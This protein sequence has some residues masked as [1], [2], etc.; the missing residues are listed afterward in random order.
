LEAADPAA[1]RERLVAP[2]DAA[3]TPAPAPQVPVEGVALDAAEE[4][5]GV[6]F[7][8]G[9]FDRGD[10]AA[11]DPGTEVVPAARLELTLTRAGEQGA[12][13][14]LTPPGGQRGILPGAYAFTLPQAVLRDLA[15][16][17]YT[18]RIAAR[19][20]RQAQPSVAV[21]EPFEVP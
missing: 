8:L 16:G 10:P 12:V 2:P 7:T 13:E 20:P 15:P 5:R 18:F 21:S 6:Q 9:R 17:D 19:A 1:A 4:A 3:A 11:G 14:R